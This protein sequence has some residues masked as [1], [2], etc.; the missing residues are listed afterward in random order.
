MVVGSTNCGILVGDTVDDGGVVICRPTTG[1][2]CEISISLIAFTD[3][4]NCVGVI[5]GSRPSQRVISGGRV[6]E[7]RG[8]TLRSNSRGYTGED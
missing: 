8:H 5:R 2:S 6:G 4:I 3:S 1:V 7:F